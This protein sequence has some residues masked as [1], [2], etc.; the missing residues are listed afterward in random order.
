MQKA[1]TTTTTLDNSSSHTDDNHSTTSSEDIAPSPKRQNKKGTP[2]TPTE[3]QRKSTRNRQ[4]TL[5]NAFGNAIPINTI[6]EGSGKTKEIRFEIDSPPE[7]SKSEYPSLK[8]LIQ[9]MGFTD[10]TPQ[11]Q[12]CLKFIEASRPKHG[13]KH[14]EVVDLTT[15]PTEE[16]MADNNNEIL[17]I[18]ENEKKQTIDSTEI[19]DGEEHNKQ[20]EE[21]SKEGK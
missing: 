6:T 19:Q 10:K 18:K 14:T 11:Y 13:T 9:E 20:E 8:A 16:D 17:L 1:T 7:K 21:P 5:T 3:P 15:S 2:P 12:T 4:S